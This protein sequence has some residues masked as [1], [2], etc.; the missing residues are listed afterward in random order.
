MMKKKRFVARLRL[1]APSVL[2]LIQISMNKATAL[3]QTNTSR[4]SSPLN[5]KAA[6][7]WRRDFCRGAIFPFVRHPVSKEV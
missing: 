4:A 5:L 6:H 3:A 2:D 7:H 1:T